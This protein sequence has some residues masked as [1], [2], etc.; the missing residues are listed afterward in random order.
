MEMFT[1]EWINSLPF[2]QYQEARKQRIRFYRSKTR[3][4][5]GCDVRCATIRGAAECSN[6]LNQ[7]KGS[8]MRFEPCKLRTDIPKNPR[9]LLSCKGVSDALSRHNLIVEK[10][11]RENWSIP[12]VFGGMSTNTR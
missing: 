10:R 4:K 5:C 2:L 12:T 11:V 8:G 9:S 7:F 6:C 3:C 1:Q